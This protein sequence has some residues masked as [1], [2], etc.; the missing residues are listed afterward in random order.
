MFWAKQ[1]LH[2]AALVLFLATLLCAAEAN[3]AITKVWETTHD[4]PAGGSTLDEASIVLRTAGGD[5]IVAG[6]TTDYGGGLADVIVIKYS[7]TDG[8]TLW[9][10]RYD[11]PDRFDDRPV[12]AALDPQG[13]VVVTAVVNRLA[14]G[15]DFYTAKY[16]GTDGSVLWE[17]SYSGPA[18]LHEEPA[19]L[20]VDNSGNVVV[21]G[22]SA[23]SENDDLYLAKYNS[24]DGAILWE[25]LYNSPENDNDFARDLQ[26][27]NSGDVIVAGSAA[28]RFYTAKY[29][30]ASGNIIWERRDGGPGIGLIEVTK[31]ALDPEGN[32]IVTGRSFA[33][34]TYNTHTIKYAHADGALIWQRAFD[35]R[36]GYIDRVFTL[37][38]DG[39]G[40]PIVGG[41]AGTNMYVAEYAAADG[42]VLWEKLVG[43]GLEG[44]SA[45]YDS[46]LDAAGDIYLAGI[47]NP[48]D[49]L[50]RLSGVD[51]SVVWERTNSIGGVA[52][53]IVLDGNSNLAITATVQGD[54]Y[55]AKL[56]ADDGSLLWEKRY[57]DIATSSDWGSLSTMDR[58]G[59][60][61]VAG[62]SR[63]NYTAK[64][65][66]AD[67]ELLWEATDQIDAVAISPDIS[68][69]LAITGWSYLAPDDLPQTLFAV[70][71]VTAKRRGDNGQL[72]WEKAINA[73]TNKFSRGLALA[74]DK[75][76]NVISS[77]NYGLGPTNDIYTAK[78]RASD[79]ELL[80][81]RWHSSPG[82]DRP[83]SVVL[84]QEQN[85]FIAGYL[86]QDF[87]ITKYS[88]IDG[89][90]FWEQQ[91]PVRN[92]WIGV[93]HGAVVDENGDVFVVGGSY[94][95]LH[96][97]K[98]RGATGALLWEKS[99]S[100][101]NNR[102]VGAHEITLD[103]AGNLVLAGYYT[104]DST[105]GRAGAM[106]MKFGAADGTILW[107]NRMSEVQ[108]VRARGLSVDEAGDI[109]AGV[110]LSSGREPNGLT[111]LF[112]FK[113][114]GNTGGVISQFNDPTYSAMDAAASP[115]GTLA[116]TGERHHDLSTLL[117]QNEPRVRLD[118]RRD[119]PFLE[120]RWPTDHI[121]FQ[122]QSRSDND[123]LSPVSAWTAVPNSTA[124]N[125]VIIPIDL[126]TRSAFFRLVQ[127]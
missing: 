119:G 62:H 100:T 16:A 9:T 90:V 5:F 88:G 113:L 115:G 86:D 47:L 15:N 71:M 18:N 27:D 76:G 80:W 125:S 99:I 33:D 36:D 105:G 92:N 122:L 126:G 72:L 49:Y 1:T 23:N 118:A 78:Y 93:Q 111:G 43:S 34:A 82:D 117:F 101:G 96:V 109:I 106:F 37:N 12:D 42:A 39:N 124:T 74:V 45:V 38:V 2:P 108:F 89:S 6:T 52:Q 120:I 83:Y 127:P 54:I 91:R 123:G 10:R 31:A 20:A 95:L 53:S 41:Y 7:G 57:D 97:A 75:E 67:G 121:G 85:V 84:D 14:G 70:S 11:S 19:A 28:F 63:G 112:V 59:N 79:G 25:K 64:Y 107:Q 87:F 61:F 50:A 22:K 58:N 94:A 17:R 73:P 24:A 110:L 46:V 56:T 68:G 55:T 30:G 65:A 69:N 44:H 8:S 66:P 77:G 81:E 104:V 51:G 114:A 13:N 29:S 60:V 116:F 4:G 35:G 40:N 48:L 102:Q 26:V 98:F 103:S 32:V 3:G 21:A